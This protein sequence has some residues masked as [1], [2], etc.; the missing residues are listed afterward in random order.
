MLA[1][2]P[3]NKIDPV[4]TKLP[5]LT[6]AELETRV[7]L[8]ATFVNSTYDEVA[9]QE[10]DTALDDQLDVPINEP[11]NEPVNDPVLICC[12]LETVPTGNP[13]GNTYEAVVANEA[14]A[15]T[16]VILVAALAVVA[17]EDV[18]VNELL[19]TPVI[20]LPLPLNPTDEV[21]EPVTYKPAS[22]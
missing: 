20:P 12:E 4:T 22:I 9:D 19:T 7:G 13:D 18:V 2:D 21:T 16:N 11:T 5:V 3:L 1:E 10:E 6:C 8:F 14:V 15:G 17:K